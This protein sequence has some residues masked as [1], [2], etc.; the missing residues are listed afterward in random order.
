MRIGLAAC[1]GGR[2]AL[3]SSPGIHCDVGCGVG[4]FPSL[5]TESWSCS[6]GELWLAFVGRDLEV[7]EPACFICS[8]KFLRRP[9]H[10]CRYGKVFKSHLFC[11]P[12]IVSCDQELNHFILQ[13]ED[14][15]FQCSYPR[16]IHGILGKSSMIVVVGDTHKKLRNLALTLVATTKAR[17][18][19]LHDIERIALRIM[20]SWK[21]KKRIFF[22]EEA[23]K[24]TFSVI[25]KQVLG[26]SQDEP[27]TAKILEDFLTFMKGLISFP[28][29][30]PGS[31]ISLSLSLL[32]NC[33]QGHNQASTKK[34]TPFGGGPRLCPGS[35]LAKVEVAF[36][37]HFMVL[38]FR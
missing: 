31:S 23:R 28:L 13:N 25:V 16:P 1:D 19:Y 5:V 11:T 20:G 12:T 14:K 33:E 34:F 10:L 9:T 38:N 3:C 29:Y 30:I 35:E 21:D 4:P 8:W 27:Q 7:F 26:L 36:F 17:A 24:F 6:K 32:A 2:A 18:G 22:C 15:L 37:L